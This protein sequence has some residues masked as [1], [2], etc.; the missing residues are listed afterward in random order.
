[1]RGRLAGQVAIGAIN[2]CAALPGGLNRKSC[3]DLGRGA[4]EDTLAGERNIPRY[5][6]HRDRLVTTSDFRDITLRTPGVD[7]GRVEVLPLFH[8]V[9]KTN[10]S[11]QTSPGI[12]TVLVIPQFDPDQPDA[13]KPDRLFL[14]AVC[15]WLDTRR[16]LTTEVF[17]RGPEYLSIWVSVGLVAQPGQVRELVHR[18]VQQAIRDYLS[19]LIGGPPV[20]DAPSSD[21]ECIDPAVPA[22]NELCPKPRGV[23]WPL[24][25]QVRR[26]DLEAVATRVSDVRYVDSI[27]LRSQTGGW[28]SV[29]RC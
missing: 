14:K 17:V 21:V 19:P 9:S 7:M 3:R 8:L 5:L 4:G 25:M 26:L 22:P 15:R 6:K 23:G 29:D 18:N 10:P 13:P 27:Q 16:L 20:T 2:K 28:N 24:N 11:D 12:V 1:M